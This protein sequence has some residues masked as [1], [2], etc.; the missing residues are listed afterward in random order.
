M[1]KR[2][3]A[4]NNFQILIHDIEES[5]YKSIVSLAQKEK[6]SVGKQAEYMLK[7]QHELNLKQTTN[8]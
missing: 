2:E 6:R 3:K 7:N 1:K 4:K 5:L 8:Q